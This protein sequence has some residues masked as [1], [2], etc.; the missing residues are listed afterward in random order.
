VRRN[1]IFGIGEYYHIYNRGTDKRKIFLDHYDLDRFLESMLEFNSKKPLGSL[2]ENSFRKRGGGKKKEIVRFVAYSLLPNHFHFLLKEIT[3]GGISKFMH[4]MAGYSWYFNNRYKR[5]GVLFQGPFKAIHVNSDNY[6]K[7]LS[8]YINLNW[9]GHQLGARGAKLVR[10]SWD[11]YLGKVEKEKEIC[12][13]KKIVL[14]QF[15]SRKDY[16]KFAKDS[17][18]QILERK[19]EKKKMH[20]FMLE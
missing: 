17:L 10:T 14:G 9:Q 6:L 5:S 15:R 13:G 19:E 11:E 16:E 4:K 2:Y 7:H 8:V 18:K 20:E 3:D 1:N 12:S